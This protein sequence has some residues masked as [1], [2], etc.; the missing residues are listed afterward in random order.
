MK[1]LTTISLFIFG[2]IITAIL[3]AGL[4]FYQNKKDSQITNSEQKITKVEAPM[5]SPDIKK[6]DSRP[7]TLVPNIPLPK[8][9]VP[10]VILPSSQITLNLAE[11]SKHNSQSDCWLLI[12]VKVYDITSYFGSH[13]GGDSRMAATCGKDAT[14]AYATQNP[15]STS[16]NGRSAHSSKAENMLDNYYVGD[17]NQIMSS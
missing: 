12:N 14:A 4:L 11:I 15:R 16:S 5:I 8:T 2:V 10:P 9:T 6:V 7:N 17:L 3:V 1:K 13:P